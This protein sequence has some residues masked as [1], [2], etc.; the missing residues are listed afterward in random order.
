MDYMEQNNVKGKKILLLCEDFFSYDQAI[1]EELKKMGAVDV[2]LK[3]ARFFR[4][5]LRSKE[6]FRI[7]KF[8]SNPF[9]QKNWTL[10]FEKEIANKSFDI[11]LCIEN[12]CFSKSFMTF[13]R[14][15]NPNIKCVLFLWDKYNTQQGGYKDYRFLFDKVYSFD[16]DDCSKYGMEYLP[17]FYLPQP[18]PEQ[19]EY[20]ISFVG[21]ARRKTTIHRFALIDYIHRFCI[22][23]NLKSFLYLR[24]STPDMKKYNS[25]KRFLKKYLF[26]SKYR[27]T[28]A[29]YKGQPWLQSQSIPLDVCNWHQSHAKA[30]LDLNHTNRQGMTLNAIAAIAHGQ[31]L[32]TTNKRIKE[33]D[34]YDP[35]MIYIIDEA[36]PYLD[37]K[38]FSR[39]NK[40]VDISFLRIDNWLNHILKI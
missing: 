38:F 16:K 9:E 1:A 33:E 21:T 31:K 23:N 35:D 20:D 18:C 30:L 40:K 15:H 3:T 2:H 8:L 4:S 29:R 11:F 13:L 28:Y 39:P 5:S 24:A 19:F 25:A 6:S 27:C 34:F 10:Q 7:K 12:A 37:I 14:K 17:D 22:R 36:N 32:I 26:R